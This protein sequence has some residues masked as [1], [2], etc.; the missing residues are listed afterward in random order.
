MKP[1]RAWANIDLSVLQENYRRLRQ[2]LPSKKILAVVKADAYGH[3]S[4]P[5]SRK[6]EAAG[7]DFLGVGTSQEA[8][9]LREAG[10]TCPVLV[11]GALVEPD[12]DF[13]IEADVSVTIHS[14]GR[15][16]ELQDVAQRLGKRLSVHLLVDTGMARLGVS[17]DQAVQHA[18]TI[19]N[20]SHL[21]LEGIGTHLASPSV[22]E[23]V[24]RQRRSFRA[25]TDQLSSQGI[26]PTFIHIDASHA[27]LDNADSSANM[28]RTGGA[29]YGI[30]DG[31]SRQRPDWCA[32]FEPI[33]S[34][35]SQI[36]Y[37][38]DHPPGQRIG[39]GGTFTTMKNCRLATIPIGYHDGFPTTLSNR[40]QVLVRGIRVPVVGKVTMD[41]TIIDVTEVE[42]AIVGDEV[43]L[44]GND[45]E[46]S[47]AA[48]EIAR[49]C[50]IGPY[51]VTCLLGRRIL[52]KYHHSVSNTVELEGS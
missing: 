41:Y 2:R 29:L 51:E 17:A 27:A 15:I 19:E 16:Q 30:L 14:P 26:S 13:I 37:L 49:W 33:L 50:G 23:E 45:G 36:V 25:I 31:I 10:I 52:R 12:L 48:E 42:G 7:I 9:E 24:Q 43:T 18:L 35:K 32:V 38:R 44:L 20:S 40:G 21:H 39:Y 47:I 3:G 28:I 22:A 34:L 46:S 8:I 6:L 5:I 1:D 4:L 11:L